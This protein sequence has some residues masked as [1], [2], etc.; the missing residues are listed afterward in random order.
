MKSGPNCC[1]MNSPDSTM[2]IL[3][4][5]SVYILTFIQICEKS[6]PAAVPHILDFSTCQLKSQAVVEA[7]NWL[8]GVK[9]KPNN[10]GAFNCH[11]L[12][13]NPNPNLN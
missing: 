12:V 2:H 4:Y 6:R 9:A 8:L 7:S 13:F 1:R 11:S 10:L 5:L 3:R